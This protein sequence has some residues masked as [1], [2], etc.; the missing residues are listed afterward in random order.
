Y[1]ETT[2]VV[3]RRPAHALA[4][5]LERWLDGP[6]AAVPTPERPLPRAGVWVVDAEILSDTVLPRLRIAP[7][8]VRSL[9]LVAWWQLHEFSGVYGANVWALSRRLRRLVQHAAGGE[10]RTAAFLRSTQVGGDQAEDFVRRVLPYDFPVAT[11]TFVPLRV[12]RRLHLYRLISQEGLFERGEGHDVPE[13]FRHP[14]LVA[15]RE[16]ARL[17][18]PTFVQTPPEVPAAARAAVAELSVGESP[19]GEVLASD[20]AEA[21]ASVRPLA[22]AD[23][24]ALGEHLASSGRAAAGRE[25]HLAISPPSNPY[26]EFLLGRIDP[27]LRLRQIGGLEG[28]ARRLVCAEGDERLLRRHLL[29]ALNERPDTREGLQ[30]DFLREDAAIRLT[31]DRLAETDALTRREVRFLDERG[32]LVIDHRFASREAIDDAHRPLDTVGGRLLEVLDPAAGHEPGRGVRLR[33]DPERSTLLAY[34]G[35]IFPSR[36]KL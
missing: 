33:L 36:G 5:R 24:L 12:A 1:L 9:G 32:R 3:T 10:A 21:G 13:Q 14:A 4:A 28:A 2:L 35:R 19:L 30:R 34:P 20:P 11:K 15:A 7:E 23:A 16:S 29:L 26:V 6:R 17:A 27:R 25:H 22:E 8:A 18:W 31:L